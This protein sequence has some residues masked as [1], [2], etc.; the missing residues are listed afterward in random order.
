MGYTHKLTAQL[1]DSFTALALIGKQPPVLEVIMEL[2]NK[3]FTIA[4]LPG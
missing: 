2:D 3:L 4:Q 1:Q